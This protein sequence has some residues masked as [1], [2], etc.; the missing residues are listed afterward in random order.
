[1]LLTE[2]HH[3][4]PSLLVNS[5]IFPLMFSIEI[6]YGLWALWADKHPVATFTNHLPSGKHTKSHGKSP[7]LSGKS[8]INGHLK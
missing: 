5:L 8:A 1:M 6:H 4:E 7:F 2:T 3:F